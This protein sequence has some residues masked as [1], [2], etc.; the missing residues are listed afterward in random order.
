M[1]GEYDIIAVISYKR[2][3][4]TSKERMIT[5]MLNKQPD[6]VPVAPDMS[7]MIPCRLTGLPFWDVYLYRKVPL[8]KA[9]IKAVKYFGFDGW[10]PATFEMEYPDENT[11]IVEKTPEKIITRKM[12]KVNGKEIVGR[13]EYTCNM[14]SKLFELWFVEVL[15]FE[16]L[17]GSVIILDRA[18]TNVVRY[19]HRKQVLKK[20]AEQAGCRVI[21]L[22]A[23]SPDFN[24][25]EHTWANLK[26]FIK[27]FMAN[28]SSLN[29][30]INHYFHFA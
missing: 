6:M 27:N 9:Y 12:E 23:Y 17:K 10:L 4:M 30:A 24:P 19:R 20:L 11:Y 16:I 5:A 28:F 1:G 22:P 13:C 29:D 8:W 14:N 18:R 2:I 26:T 7:N 3:I 15:L 21:F 25:I